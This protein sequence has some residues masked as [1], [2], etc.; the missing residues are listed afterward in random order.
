MDEKRQE[1]RNGVEASASASAS[2]GAAAAADDSTKEKEIGHDKDDVVGQEDDDWKV[3]RDASKLEGDN[4]FRAGDYVT[5]IFHYSAALS[6][7]PTHGPLLSNRSAAYLKL[8]SSGSSSGSNSSTSGSKSKALHDAMACVATGTMGHKGISRHAAALQALGRYAAALDQ[9]EAILQGD[10]THA[11]ALAGKQACVQHMLLLQEAAALQ[12]QQQQK[13]QAEKEKESAEEE[14]AEPLDDL[15]DFFNDVEEAAG[16]VANEKKIAAMG[17]PVMATEAIRNH[18]KD[19]GTAAEQIERILPDN[20][21]WY[22]LN[23][24]HVLDLPHTVDKE[25]ISRRF[26]ALSLLLHPDKNQTSGGG[27]GAAGGASMTME[28][29]QLAYDQVLAAKAVLYDDDKLKHVRDLIE[30]GMIQGRADWEKAAKATMTTTTNINTNTTTGSNLDDFQRKAVQRLF[31]E[32]EHTRRQV[33][34]RE[35]SFQQREQETEDAIA[36]KEKNERTFDK[37]WKKEERVD[38]RIG[39]WRDFSTKRKKK[40]T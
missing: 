6:V 2:V 31:A 1:K 11:A 34:K 17:P 37:Q 16:A 30:Q 19:L 9:W 14:E 24:F 36:T 28:Q 18:K 38:K 39:D 33:V 22:N 26:K 21:V 7:D 32:I 15:D 23:P 25:E 10:A 12:Q 4:A 8:S 20:Y 27:G 29:V 40:S 13:E 5:A 35:R 3:Q